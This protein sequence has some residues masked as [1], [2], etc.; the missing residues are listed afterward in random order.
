MAQLVD[1]KASL[2][3]FTDSQESLVLPHFATALNKAA[4]QFATA[5][6]AKS[7]DR[8][9]VLKAAMDSF[10]EGKKSF[11]NYQKFAQEV[12]PHTNAAQQLL[13][14]GPR[15]SAVVQKQESLTPASTV[16]DAASLA[17][18][19]GIQVVESDDRAG[20]DEIQ[21]TEVAPSSAASLAGLHSGDVIRS[22]DGKAVRT[23][24][25]LA[26]E[27]AKHPPGS[28]VR[29]R[30]MFHTSASGWV[31]NEAVVTLPQNR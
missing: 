23:P 18:T 5:L 19:I 20:E 13:P 11:S 25:E 3:T 29:V 4:Q 12:E 7:D 30:V 9:V 31:S 1:A 6:N 27:L 2:Q 10:A 15:S 28:Q 8:A 16:S 17:R 22:L 21:I 24:T 14:N 26:A